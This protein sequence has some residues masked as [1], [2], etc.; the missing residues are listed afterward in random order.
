[1]IFNLFN[2]ITFF[3]L[4]VLNLIPVFVSNRNRRYAQYQIK[5][6]AVFFAFYWILMFYNFQTFDFLNLKM[7]N[8][9]A[10]QVKTNLYKSKYESVH[11]LKTQYVFETSN[12][13]N[14]LNK[15]MRITIIQGIIVIAFSVFSI[16][17][18]NARVDYYKRIIFIQLLLLL[19][20]FI[21]LNSGAIGGADAILET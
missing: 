18:L 13:L 4:I 2:V 21:V 3:I 7:G 19:F 10:K 14:Q 15:M 1:M 17:W 6:F 20:C 11:K 8:A 9:P 5:G 12:K 16:V